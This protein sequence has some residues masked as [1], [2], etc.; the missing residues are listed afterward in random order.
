MPKA[1]LKASKIQD[2]KSCRGSIFCTSVMDIIFALCSV[3]ESAEDPNRLTL[4]RYDLAT[5]L[6]TG[7]DG[8]S[9]KAQKKR[10]GFRGNRTAQDD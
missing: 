3:Q 2:R 1:M 6:N 10:F 5:G 7:S 4:L 9:T 8:V